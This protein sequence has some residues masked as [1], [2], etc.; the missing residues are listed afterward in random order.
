MAQL[1]GLGPFGEAHLRDQLRLNP[2][3]A[4]SRRSAIAGP[5]QQR[6]VE[7]RIVALKFA[8]RAAQAG[9]RRVAESCPD[10]ARV[11]EPAVLVVVAEQQR[12]EMRSRT[13]RVGEAADQKLL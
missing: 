6:S 1:P 3:H 12:T 2:M 8:H 4:A 11:D 5:R 9:Q 10:L 7:G 13:L